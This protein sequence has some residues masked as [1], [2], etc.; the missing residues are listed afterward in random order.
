MNP[1][2]RWR[3]L[4]AIAGIGL[5]LGAGA[6]AQIPQPP[7]SQPQRPQQPVFDEQ[8]QPQQPVLERPRLPQQPV[9]ERP[10]QPPPRPTFKNAALTEASVGKAIL[11]LRG[12]EN[13]EEVQ[14]LCA[15]PTGNVV[16][17]LLKE[18]YVAQAGALTAES[19]RVSS[20]APNL[21][22]T[23]RLAGPLNPAEGSSLTVK[24]G[25][26][27]LGSPTSPKTA[28]LT[29]TSR[30]YTAYRCAPDVTGV[31]FA[32][33]QFTI[34][35][36]GLT[37]TAPGSTRS[38][39]VHEVAQGSP[40]TT[41]PVVSATNVAGGVRVGLAQPPNLAN[42]VLRFGVTLSDC[43][44][45]RTSTSKIV[46]SES[47]QTVP[48]T[49]ASDAAEF[50]MPGASDNNAALNV[51][52]S[53]QLLTGSETQS[54]T[55]FQVTIGKQHHYQLFPVNHG[56]AISN[57]TLDYS[58]TGPLELGRAGINQADH[59]EM[60]VLGN[61]QNQLA[62]SCS[63]R[64]A[65]R[66]VC[67]VASVPASSGPYQLR[68]PLRTLGSAS[69]PARIDF[70]AYG[71]GLTE[72]FLSSP[73][74]VQLDA[75]NTADRAIS[76]LTA[77][78]GIVPGSTFTKAELRQITGYLLRLTLINNGPADLAPP[79]RAFVT[80]SGLPGDRFGWQYQFETLPPGCTQ[81]TPGLPSATCILNEPLAPAQP[82]EF[83]IPFRLNAHI[84][85]DGS[86]YPSTGAP[87]VE[88]P[89]CS[90]ACVPTYIASRVSALAQG[91][92][93]DPNLANDSIPAGVGNQPFTIC[94]GGWEALEPTANGGF[95]RIRCRP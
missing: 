45:N 36:T 44:G 58:A 63:V 10:S 41:I 22:L 81:Q 49:Q 14:G 20:G 34:S 53:A 86:N 40:F 29:T 74:N 84:T 73:V 50:R 16:C 21:L 75:A 12:V 85:V 32:N 78:S 94:A 3:I 92:S 55:P 35:G 23:C 89:A 64:T 33:N 37:A 17:R 4:S 60:F 8:P 9:L 47:G 38:I 52:T 13:I 30:T 7:S 46:L 5:A 11:E 71:G 24:L 79:V 61:F 51:G 68:L 56:T 95:S 39:S 76:S 27:S 1:N 43:I 25:K 69:A 82:R 91:P 90:P 28:H 15:D 83:V 65:N 87:G 93:L 18:G 54:T 19:C 42:K 88:W 62:V 57:L 6:L 80:L 26:G 59:P 67:Q 31:T 70:R 72:Q 77:T 48:A 66:Y 2:M